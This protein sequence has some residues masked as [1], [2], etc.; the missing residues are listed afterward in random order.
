MRRVSW[1]STSRSS[2]SRVSSSARLIASFVISWKTIRL[3]GTFGCSTSNRCQA[4]AS[5]S[6]SSSV[7][8]RSSSAS[9][10]SFFSSLT[11]FFLSGSTTYSGRKSCSTSTPTRDPFSFLYSAGMSAARSGRSRMW[12]T[13]DSTT[14]PSPRYPAIVFALAGDSTMTRRFPLPSRATAGQDSAVASERHVQLR[15]GSQ[16]T[17]AQQAVSPAGAGNREPARRGRLRPRL[18]SRLELR[19][20]AARN[21]ALS[22]PAAAL[23]GEV[24]ALLVA[25]DL[26]PERRRRVPGAA[27]TARYG[28]DRDRRRA[29]PGRRSRDDVPGR[30]ASDEGPREEVRGA[31]PQRCRADRS[32]GRL[33]ARPCGGEGHRRPDALQ[34]PPRRI[35]RTGRDRRPAR[36]GRRERRA[37]G[38]RTIDGADP[39]ARGV[40]V[41]TLLAIDG[42]SFAH[43][44]YHSMPKSVR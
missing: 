33:A 10:R 21:A 22:P 1:A 37:R 39:R 12:P 15:C 38:D 11:F 14:K 41:T 19:S 7:A 29:R 13:L 34:Q 23:H 24:G 2:M 30:D 32:R 26:R 43:R 35:R 4:I 6:R 8:S 36:T 40:L 42:D 9:L 17:G 28:G 18:Q 5:P 27:R 31:A 25:A 16:P 44:A 3:T 20:L